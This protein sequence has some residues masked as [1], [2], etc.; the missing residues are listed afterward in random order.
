MSIIVAPYPSIQGARE[1]LA[2]IYKN[3]AAFI[4]AVKLLATEFGHHAP[5]YELTDALSCY[6]EIKGCSHCI[7]EKQ[8]YQ[9]SN[10]WQ[11]SV[12]TAARRLGW[13]HNEID[14]IYKSVTA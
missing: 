14:W 3:E 1:N 8:D 12:I 11:D 6:S 9:S 10:Q 2:A 4:M 7:I 5:I 13:F